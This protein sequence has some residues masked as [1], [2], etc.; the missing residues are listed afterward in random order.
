MLLSL[1]MQNHILLLDGGTGTLLQAE[2]LKSG[3]S[4]E[5]WVISHPD[6]IRRMHLSY[7]QAG[8]HV[9]CTDTFGANLLHFEESELRKIIP[10]AVRL[11]RE[12]AACADPSLPRFVALDIGPTG[13]L[14]KPYGDLD[15]EKAV[16]IFKTSIRLGLEEGPDLI[17]IETMNDSYE[18]K[19]AL[20]AARECTDLPV[21]VSNAYGSDA[22][23]MTG[24]D[25]EAMTVML[26]GMG[27]AA[28]GTNCSLGPDA[29][30]PVVSRYLEASSLPVLLKPNAGLPRVENGK[31]V[32]D[33]SPEAFAA[34]VADMVR[35]G[36]RIV[37]GCCGT[38]PAYISALS[39]CLQGLEPV[40]LAEKNRTVV[41]GTSHAVYFGGKPVLIGERINPTGK[42]RF[43]QALQEHDM[44]YILREGISQQDAG[45]DMLD[46]NVGLPGLDEAAVLEETV[47]ELQAVSDLP[48]QLDTSDPEAMGR[49]LRRYN[50]KALINSVSGKKESMEAVFPLQKKYGGVII[51]LTLD[52][53]GIPATAQG[54][55][56]VAKKILQEAARYGISPKD[57]IFDP[58]AMTVSSSPDAASVT[59]EAMRLIREETGCCTSLGVSNISFG[60][61][62]RDGINS[63]FFTLALQN[64]LSGAIMNPH[65]FDMMRTYHAFLALSGMD[66][67][68]M[69]YIA[70]TA[71]HAPQAAAPLQAQAADREKNIAE[72]GSELQ[73]AIE[74]GLRE[75]AGR[76]AHDMLASCEPLSLISE[77]IVP[78][79]NAVGI[80]F[81]QKT[82]FLPQLL[83][84]AEAA[85]AAFEVIRGAMQSTTGP[86]HGPF[87]LATVQG[88]IH[89]IGKNIVRLLLESYGFPVIDLGKDVPPENV[90][91]AVLE[92][93]AGMCG[94]SAL[95]TTTV[96]AMEDTIRLVHEKAP[97]CRV[98]VGGAVL[99]QSYA[100]TIGADYYAAD[101]MACVR[102]AQQLDA[103]KA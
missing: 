30:R 38:T 7:Y 51:C 80:R 13:Q 45:A 68:C 20:L 57:L 79:L 32:Y 55:L 63:T 103:E 1:F 91:Q 48:L 43:K 22:K 97:F 2:G 54:R 67:H 88:D 98:I 36:V 16:E 56:A 35:Q 17:F 6:Q 92:N 94:L 25:P 46:V 76:L 74:K 83:M 41:S 101:A 75:Q 42:K 15:F 39:G 18:T 50:G 12:A 86:V 59:L 95:M 47:C 37:G 28:I 33:V 100:D 82:L 24:A 53:N 3:E 73:K 81:E 9:V 34:S 93:H 65:S 31:T 102:I 49:A 66:D 78:A 44:D 60:L 11:A 61:P 72:Q 90:L 69:Q 89:D 58:L 27:A 52:E 71:D 5:T 8:S 64:G 96:P 84:S 19:A 99:T 70:Y 40:P 26:E 62:Q 87:V 4:P 29:L 21:F 77:H 85:G 14:L 23:L 10:G